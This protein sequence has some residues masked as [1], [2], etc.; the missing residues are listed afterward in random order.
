M[1]NELR[2]NQVKLSQGKKVWL[3]GSQVRVHKVKVHIYDSFQMGILFLDDCSNNSW[4]K[5]ESNVSVQRFGLKIVN[6]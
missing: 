4:R 5:K 3:R 2:T 6:L 1:V